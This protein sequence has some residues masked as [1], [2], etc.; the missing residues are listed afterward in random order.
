MST[1]S[2]ELAHLQRGLHHAMTALIRQKDYD[3]AERIL[4]V[5]DIEMARMVDQMRQVEAKAR[6]HPLRIAR[7]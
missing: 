6:R 4:R 2:E 7:P 1:M 5:V 3:E